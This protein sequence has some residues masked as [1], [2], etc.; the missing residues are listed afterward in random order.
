M[1]M[2]SARGIE[3]SLTLQEPTC[4]TGSGTAVAAG[5]NPTVHGRHTIG[6]LEPD[7]PIGCV[8][9][10]R[11]IAQ[12]LFD[13]TGVERLPI[14]ESFAAM[15]WRASSCVERIILASSWAWWIRNLISSSTA[16]ATSFERS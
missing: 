16:A 3:A 9:P 12:N 8:L 15:R 7:A 11:Y 6:R 5:R 14:H 2:G 4:F 13:L 1:T 10:L